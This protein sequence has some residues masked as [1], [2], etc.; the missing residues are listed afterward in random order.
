MMSSNPMCDDDDDDVEL[1]SVC[2]G[3][4]EVEP[5]G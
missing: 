2:P 3:K 5:K 4:G 1:A